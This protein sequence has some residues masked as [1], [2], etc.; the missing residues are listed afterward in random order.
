E[1]KQPYETKKSVK[2]YKIG[3]VE[4]PLKRITVDFIKINYK[5]IRL[6]KKSA[7]TLAKQKMERLKN[8]QLGKT[9]KSSQKGKFK[10]TKKGVFYSKV[11]FC[12]ENIAKS[13]KILK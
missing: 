4:L 3:G 2:K 12:E 11:Y 9:V 10:V 1:V 8:K 5:K 7:K 13:K 6:N